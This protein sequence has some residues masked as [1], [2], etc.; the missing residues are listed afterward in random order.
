M[1]YFVVLVTLI[2]VFSGPVFAKS[3]DPEYN[4]YTH[5][6]VQMTLK[7][8]ETTQLEV[9]EKFGAPNITTLD[10]K[11]HEVWTYQKAATVSKKKT[12]NGYGTLIILSGGTETIGFSQSSK[13]MTLIIKF[14]ENKVVKD[15]KSMSTNF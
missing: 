10:S 13:T 3:N 1:K 15:F 12:R 4:P 5:G 8:G 7:N 9:L 6:N 11:Q 14:D 2:F